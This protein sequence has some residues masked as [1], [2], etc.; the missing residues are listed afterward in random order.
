MGTPRLAREKVLKIRKVGDPAFIEVESLTNADMDKSTSEAD[1][2]SNS[3]DGYEETMP[4]WSSATLT[5]ECIFLDD[6]PG[7]ELLDEAE[8]DKLHLEYQYYPGGEASGAKYYSGKCWVQ[9]LSPAS[10]DSGNV[11]SSFDL[12]IVGKPARN[13]VT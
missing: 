5:G 2:S 12:R 10:P 13:T 7:Q 6:D 9:N 1:F 11:T 3:S 4:D 8:E